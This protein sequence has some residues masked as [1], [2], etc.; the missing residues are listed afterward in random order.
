MINLVDELEAYINSIKNMS[1]E[2]LKKSNLDI[3]FGKLLYSTADTVVL[4]NTIE[5]HELNLRL[6]LNISGVP[7]V[8]LRDGH[9]NFS[10]SDKDLD[11]LVFIIDDI[12]AICE[13]VT[14]VSIAD[15]TNDMFDYRSLSHLTFNVG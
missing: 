7:T 12:Y 6:I 15:I 8:I 9:L 5:I 2:E 11:K 14:E 10:C 1:A 13:N 4:V 3:V